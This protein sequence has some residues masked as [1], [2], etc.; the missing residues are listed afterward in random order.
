MR[1]KLYAKRISGVT[2]R[3]RSTIAALNMRT[4]SGVRDI[5]SKLLSRPKSCAAVLPVMM[6]SSIPFYDLESISPS[7]IAQTLKEWSAASSSAASIPGVA[8]CATTASLHLALAPAFANTC[9]HK[10]L[11]RADTIASAVSTA[12]RNDTRLEVIGEPAGE[13]AAG[14][15]NPESSF[16]TSLVSHLL[17][18]ERARN[19]T[20]SRRVFPSVVSSNR[21][22][23]EHALQ[24]CLTRNAVARRTFLAA[25][26][27]F[28]ITVLPLETAQAR[29]I[30]CA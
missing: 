19:K 4:F 21:C 23:R 28:I 12:P 7:K 24:P 8:A 29:E 14:S 30:A 1:P 10:R 20:S 5:K 16:G 18:R 17:E 22:E 15:N 11:W 13:V 3:V 2:R 6:V 9:A 26:A 27:H 25:A